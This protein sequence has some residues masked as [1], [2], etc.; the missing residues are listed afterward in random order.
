M[1]TR[2]LDIYNHNE[3]DFRK[4]VNPSDELAYLFNDWMPYY[5]LKYAICKAIAPHSI[6]EIGVRYGYSA[7]T[8]L[9]ASPKASYI[10]IDN[11]SNTFGGTAG[12][13]QWAKKITAGR[14]AEFL[15][16]DTQQVD[17][18]PGDIYDFIHIDGQQDG[19]GTFHDLEMAL[20]K[21]CYVLV[22]G[23]FWS[24]E[25][26][27]SSTFFLEKYRK[28]IEYSLIIP[29]YAGE[30]LI[31]TK[32]DIRFSANRLGKQYDQLK[33]S[34]AETYF[35]E[36]CGGYDSF[37]KNKGTSLEDRRLLAIYY[38]A[39]PKPDQKILDIGCGRG[40]LSF[41]LAKAKA[42]VT[43][44]DYSVDAIKIARKTFERTKD[45]L[46]LQLEFYCDDIL[47]YKY[48]DKFITIVAADLIEHLEQEALE[49][50]FKK[51][52][53]LLSE[54][55]LFIIH[56]SPNKLNYIYPYKKKRKMARDAGLYLPGN[57]RTFYEDL[58]HINE[59]TPAMLK[60]SL[61]KYFNCSHVWATTL[62]E[63][64]GSLGR[65]FKMK[66]IASATSIF[67]VASHREVPRDRIISLLNQQ[68]LDPSTLDVD[69]MPDAHKIVLKK[70][71]K[72]SIA[73]RIHNK[74]HERFV[75]LPP[76]PV[77]LSYHWADQNGE[78]F[79]F[80]GERTP[81]LIPLMPD[82]KRSLDVIVRTPEREGRYLL[83]VTL[84]QEHNLWF[85]QVV[86]HLPLTISVVII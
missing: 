28:F 49:R 70:S 67:A 50:L 59:Q 85:E 24:K 3:F 7:I 27:L 57:P 77:N 56:T 10:G 34:Y 11:N 53:D 17:S 8:F 78:I 55:G 66:E 74:S 23:Y 72:A 16:I 9:E 51:T 73:I 69:L 62:P 81:L 25:N 65:V 75:S 30:L 45:E 61:K 31:K 26:M 42:A 79:L 63:M 39:D 64:S 14:K 60:R 4:F 52:S 41:A 76:Y 13:L 46:E 58:M 43:G 1:I 36:D 71:T 5:R 21:G 84:M 47:N 15:N 86:K 44:I 83:H 40:E 38:L 82:E 32:H 80:D 6:L 22:D 29:G 12:A 18:L 48:N 54:G 20:E 2:I 35:L 68:K 19:D 33:E 37:K